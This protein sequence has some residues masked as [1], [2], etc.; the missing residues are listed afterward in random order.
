MFAKIRHVSL[1]TDNYESMARFYKTI[2]GMRQFTNTVEAD[3]RVNRERGQLSDGV[4]GLAGCL[5]IRDSSP[6]W[7]ISASRWRTLKPLRAA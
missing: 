5:S 3:G 1:Y 2:F 6:A 4:I 7:I